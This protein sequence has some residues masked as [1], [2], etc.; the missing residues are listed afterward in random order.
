MRARIISKDKIELKFQFSR[1][2]IDRIKQLGD[3]K[4]SPS[5]KSW[6]VPVELDVLD[7]LFKN[8]FE[9]SDHD[10]MLLD[11]LI[12]NLGI[13][14]KTRNIKKRLSDAIGAKRQ[15]AIQ[16][17]I[18][19]IL[20]DYQW[21][22]PVYASISQARL[23]LADEMG[24]GKTIQSIAITLDER[25]KEPPVLIVC[26]ANVIYNW[27]K[28]LNEVGFKSLVLEKPITKLQKGIRYYII[29]YDKMKKMEDLDFFFI[30]D[31]AHM[32]KNSRTQRFKH[33]K[34]IT[35]DAKH[36]VL[37][38]GTPILSRPA[39]LYPLITLLDPKFMSWSAYMRRYCNLVR[40]P[41]GIE[42]SGAQNLAELHEFVTQNFMIRRTKSQ[43]LKQLPDKTRQTFEIGD[44]TID[45]A[46]SVLQLFSLNAEYKS[47]DPSFLE[48]VQNI[49]HTTDKLLIFAHHKVMLDAIEGLC[50]INHTEFMRI[51]GSVSPEKRQERVNAFQTDPNIKVAVLSITAAGVGI[52]LTAASTVIMSELYWNPASLLQC[53]DRCHRIGQRS[54]VVVL[55][56]VWSSFEKVV[57]D[58]LLQKLN[59]IKQV[60]E[61]IK[62]DNEDQE[63]SLLKQL[64]KEFSLPMGIGK[65]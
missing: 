53:E 5:K 52:T 24:L 33:A 29:S 11:K 32:L 43:V 28:E 2:L 8:N 30:F 44:V 55:Y 23:L 50:K 41:W 51:D 59:I 3:T 63:E 57:Q 13:K 19:L 58:L 65:R 64:A 39:E 37:L 38:T 6:V 12:I 14:E 34:R 26:P 49:M 25:F 60:V 7:F 48:F 20:H 9:F 27:Q 17:K 45:D 46:K 10:L 40:T 16:A 62:V 35:K 15:D 4:W 47:T 56:P 42:Y 22:P 21:V 31:E 18:K 1:E 61:G 36:I 54:N